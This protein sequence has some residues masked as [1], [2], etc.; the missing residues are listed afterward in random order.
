MYLGNAW[1]MVNRA[2]EGWGS[3]AQLGYRTQSLTVFVEDVDAYFRRAK[4]AGAK[5]AEDL[6]ETVYGERQYGAEDL[7]RHHWLFSRHAKDLRPEE[8]GARVSESKGRVQLLPRP[9]LCYLEIPA[10]DLRESVSFYEKVFGW[11]IRR[12]E[13]AHPSFD[14]ATGDVSGAWVT[15]REILREPGLLPYIWV[16]SIDGSWLKLRR[17]AGRSSRRRTSTPPADAGLPRFAIRRAT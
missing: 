6:N 15:G 16:D 17:T 9:R 7:D 10:M 5:I 4:A 1:I 8:W 13:S 2:R 12:R 14:D 3:P 11:N